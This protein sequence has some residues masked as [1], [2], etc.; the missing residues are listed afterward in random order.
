MNRKG[1]TLVELLGVIVIIGLIVGLSTFGIIRVY[2]NSKE[3]SI[4]LSR[5]SV[6]EAARIFA[7]EKTNDE[8]RWIYKNTSGE[9]YTYFCMTVK[10]LINNGLLD[11]EKASSFVE[12]YVVVKKNKITFDIDELKI[13]EKDDLSSDVTASNACGSVPEGS[14]DAPTIEPISSYTD[15]IDAS[16]T[17][18]NVEGTI[19]GRECL[20]NIK[21]SNSLLKGEVTSD[22]KCLFKKLKS[23]TEYDIKVC[24][25]AD[26]NY[27]CSSSVSYKTK[28]IEKPTFSISDGVDITFKDDNIKSTPSH[29]FKSTA[30]GEST[31]RVK[32]CTLK[33]NKFTCDDKETNTI[34]HNVWYK[35]DKDSI[36]LKNFNGNTIITARTEDGSGNYNENKSNLIVHKITFNKG[37]ADKIGGVTSNLEYSCVAENNGSCTIKSPSIEKT[38]YV[39]LGWN[40]S[41][42]GTTSEWD[43]EVEREISTDGEYYPV[44]RPIVYYV[45]YYNE[46][47]LNKSGTMENS[48]HVYDVG[49]VLNENQFECYANVY[50]EYNGAT[51]GNSV[52]NIRL[53]STFSGWYVKGQTISTSQE[54]MNLT[55]KEN[56]IVSANAY[57]YNRGTRLPTPTK[58]GYTFDGWYSDSSFSTKVG[59]ANAMYYPSSGET[60]LYAKWTTNRYTVTYNYS[61][62]GGTSSTKSTDYIYYGS[63]VDLTPT[64]TKEGWTF[65]GWNTDRNA[66]TGLT[67]LVMPANSVTLY[68]IFKTN[69]VTVKYNVNGGNITQQTTSDSGTIY[70]WQTSNTGTISRS[71]N[72]GSYTS[73]FFTIDY[74][75]ATDTNGLS[76]YANAKYINIKKTGYIA[77][78]NNE[79]KCLTTCAKTTYSQKGSYNDSDFCSAKNGDCTVELGVN[80]VPITYNIAY[81][82]TCS[83]KKSGTMDNSVHTYNVSK[84]LSANNY[85]CSAT[86]NYEYNGATGGNSTSS[87]N[88]SS[89]LTGWYYTNGG[90]SMYMPEEE[91]TNL[92]STNDD[93]ITLD[94]AWQNK[95]VTLPTPTKDG[96]IFDGWYKDSSFSVKVGDGGASYRPDSETVNL[97]AKWIRND[98]K[99]TYNYSNNGGTSSTK[100][101]DNVTAGNNVDLSVTASKS[102]WTFVGWNTNKDATTKLDSYVMPENDITLYAIFKKEAITYTAKW[103]N[104][105]TTLSS[106]SDSTC[107]INEV[108]NNGT[109]GTSCT[110]TAPTITRSGY[111]IIGFNNTISATSSSLASGGTLTLNSSNNGKTWYAIT[112][113]NVGDLDIT[114]SSTREEY[115]QS[116]KTPSVTIKDGITTL[117]KDTDYTVSY[118]DN[119]NIGTATI[120]INGK[121]VYNSTTKTFYVSSTTRTFTISDTI[122]P[123][124]EIKLYEG[125]SAT[126]TAKLTCTSN[127]NESEKTCTYNGNINSSAYLQI[128]NLTDS[129]SGVASKWYFN[130][131]AS[132]L[133]STSSN[134][135]TK[136]LADNKWVEYATSTKGRAI[137]SGGYRVLW[138]KFIDN[139]GNEKTLIIKFNLVTCSASNPYGCSTKYVCGDGGTYVHEMPYANSSNIAEGVT[140]HVFT[141]TEKSSHTIAYIIGEVNSPSGYKMYLVCNKDNHGTSTNDYQGPFAENPAGSYHTTRISF[142]AGVDATYCGYIYYGC[143]SDSSTKV[144]PQSECKG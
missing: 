84:K 80:W 4:S 118:S 22:N 46:C 112:S 106:T 115:N 37:T 117:T 95:S 3:K 92:S 55:D 15:E 101:T 1:F 89:D 103:N 17:D 18:S 41:D 33:N 71:K 66:T 30:I 74:G 73:D 27:K 65:V 87:E 24:V 125:S 44:F 40:S 82:N 108:Y 127:A 78:K 14:L 102:G 133:T 8:D 28:D 90:I 138:F 26:N 7:S 134:V 52:T 135:N 21:G 96:S 62:N 35:T 104:N 128:S 75:T 144:C 93:T 122:R 76:N 59:K 121:S 116:A 13:V 91:I 130:Y 51:G 88:V 83:L 39:P 97:Y 9:D 81:N 120:T 20:Y 45:S 139:A 105:G 114:L 111:N 34:K 107:T 57:W 58:E 86:V 124:V 99:V 94:T 140:N 141:I 100:S 64:A 136:A 6:L 79:W 60:T 143:L 77:E 70:N 123:N 54:V 61:A 137:A 126:G 32:T 47:N 113:K 19:T 63:N 53:D 50:Y 36:T 12:D 10:E 72:N 69:K 131:N 23:N 2:N 142:G 42:S 68:A 48:T 110:V 25:T 132:N 67:S 98:Y 49:K 119:T 109:Q 43:A 38:G 56:D 16:F 29:Y 5:N 129:G 85:S 31:E 11:K